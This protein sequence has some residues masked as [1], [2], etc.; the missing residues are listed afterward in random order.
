MEKQKSIYFSELDIKTFL[1]FSL[2]VLKIVEEK[3]PE[4]NNA[5]LIFANLPWICMNSYISQVVHII[6]SLSC[7]IFSDF[8]LVRNFEFRF[9]ST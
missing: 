5:E 8:W 2:K 1:L 7:F 4:Q 6:C 9:F 3:I